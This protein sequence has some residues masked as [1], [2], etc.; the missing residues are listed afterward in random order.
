MTKPDAIKAAMSVGISK[1]K[2][3]YDISVFEKEVWNK[4]IEAAAKLFPYGEWEKINLADKI[5]KLK[6]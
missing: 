3:Y 1:D 2:E 6:K 5:R 4:A